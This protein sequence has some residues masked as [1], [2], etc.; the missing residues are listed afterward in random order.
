M[1]HFYWE[2]NGTIYSSSEEM[3]KW[4]N[5]TLSNR[6][7]EKKNKL[8]NWETRHHYMTKG[9]TGALNKIPILA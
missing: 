3:E 7:L 6:K 2:P 8:N 4:K 1:D 5:A 9:C